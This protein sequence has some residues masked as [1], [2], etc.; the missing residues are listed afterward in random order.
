MAF[1]PVQRFQDG[2]VVTLL[3][4]VPDLW[5]FAM[6]MLSVGFGGIVQALFKYGKILQQKRDDERRG[7][8]KKPA[9]TNK[10]EIQ[11]V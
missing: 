9:S 7:Q 4:I 8:V 6:L 3:G 2:A 10:A 11:T 5:I 1:M